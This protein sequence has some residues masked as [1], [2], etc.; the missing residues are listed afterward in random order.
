MCCRL[1]SRDEFNCKDLIFNKPIGLTRSTLIE[2]DNQLINAIRI[3]ERNYVVR[4]CDL[5]PR[6]TG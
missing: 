2:N 5:A 3:E 4:F 6:A 1:R